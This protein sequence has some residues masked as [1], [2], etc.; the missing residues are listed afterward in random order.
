MFLC[1]TVMRIVPPAS[2]PFLCHSKILMQGRTF[3]LSGCPFLWLRKREIRVS[4]FGGMSP[5]L[6]GPVIWMQFTVNASQ[7]RI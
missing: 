5:M 4:F 6:Y 1:A 2:S 3:C 7:S